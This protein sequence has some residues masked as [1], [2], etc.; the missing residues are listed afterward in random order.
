MNDAVIQL[1]TQIRDELRAYHASG[2]RG[3]G[4]SSASPRAIE[5]APDRELDSERGDPT[6]G[7]DPPRWGKDGGAP[8]VGRTY[9]ECSPDFLDCLASFLEWKVQNPLPDRDPKYA[10]YDRRDCARALGWARRLRAGW[11]RQQQQASRYG[12][13]GH[14]GSAKHSGSPE[15]DDFGYDS[16]EDIPF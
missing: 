15:A 12:T 14:G 6:I 2:A 11:V 13:S 10:D 7:K 4:A 3:P 5:A 16:T 9:S 8:M 1:L